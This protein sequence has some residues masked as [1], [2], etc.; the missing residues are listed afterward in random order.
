MGG[1]DMEKW[2]R[3]TNI[4]IPLWVMDIKGRQQTWQQLI[5]YGLYV[6]QS[7]YEDQIETI[8]N[9]VN[10]MRYSNVTDIR[11]YILDFSVIVDT[12]FG[13]TKKLSISIDES[14]YSKIEDICLILGIKI[15]SMIRLCIYHSMLYEKEINK[16]DDIYIR[17]EIS[18]LKDKIKAREDT[19]LALKSVNDE[20]LKEKKD[21]D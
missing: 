21:E 7:K 18:T 19:L 8:H 3:T 2:K 14:T 13:T 12:F 17:E 4:E 16:E 9:L 11:D 5:D 1:R 6:V 20:W 15:S 10:Q